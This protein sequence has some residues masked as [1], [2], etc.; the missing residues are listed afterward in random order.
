MS[1]PAYFSSCTTGGITSTGI[2]S[3][4]TNVDPAPRTLA[5]VPGEARR[6]VS[7]EAC[8]HAIVVKASPTVLSTVG[9]VGSLLPQGLLNS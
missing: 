4:C 2:S 9:D 7:V 8:R 1:A 6:Y 5:T 3:L